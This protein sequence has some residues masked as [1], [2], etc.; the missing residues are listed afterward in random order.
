LS[1]RD[2]IKLL[3]CDVNT[4]YNKETKKE[5]VNYKVFDF[6]M[7]DGSKPVTDDKKNANTASAKRTAFAE[8]GDVDEGDVPEDDLPF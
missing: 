3:A 7:A 5:Y 2:R 1:E 8:E 6:E 4:T